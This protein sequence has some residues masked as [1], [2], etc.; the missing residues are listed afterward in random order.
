MAEDTKVETTEEG[1]VVGTN[2]DARLKILQQ[3]NDQNDASLAENGDLA[4]VNDDGTT[5][6]FTKEETLSDEE[7]TAK[8][9]Q[10]AEDE[11]NLTP[12]DQPE[13][14][15]HKIKVNGKELELTTDE[16]VQRAQKVESA[17]TYLKEATQKLRDA[18]ANAAK[19]TLPSTEDVTAKADERR[20]LVRAI[21]MGTED[22][23]MAAIEKLQGRTPSVS[24]DD[25]ARTVDERLTFNDAV[26]RFQK[27]YKDLADDPVLLN[28]VLQR[29]KEL[30]AQGD[31]RSYQE[32]YEDI[33]NSVRT[34]KEGLTKAA[35]PE[36][37]KPV[38]D[39]QTRK[40]SAPAVPQ[41]AGTKAP[42]AVNDEDKEEFVGDV[43]SAMAKAR[44]GPQWLRS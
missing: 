22:E 16:L 11:A 41:G 37:E 20:A 40:A 13:Q 34:W 35:T 33:G 25:V 39:K 2:N 32:R 18:E 29:D 21:Q 30:I 38:S 23:A 31:K 1:D 44:G 27:D 15:K 3:I 9:L 12:E 36:P 24:A 10:R 43:I 42:A 14:P 7:V 4:D 28:I 6:A 8:E 17:D 19:P 5:S 26:S